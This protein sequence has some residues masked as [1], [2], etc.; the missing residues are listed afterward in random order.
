LS[1]PI[2][3]IAGADGLARVVTRRPPSDDKYNRN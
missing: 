1:M 2:N 3:S